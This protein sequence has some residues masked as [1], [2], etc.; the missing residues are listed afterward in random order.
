MQPTFV[1]GDRVL[2]KDDFDARY[3]GKT[4]VVED[5]ESKSPLSDLFTAPVSF[6]NTNL[7]DKVDP[8]KKD[9]RTCFVYNLEVAVFRNA[10]C[11]FC[12]FV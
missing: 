12:L 9:T 8:Q 5:R 10:R 3:I 4:G 6:F 11:T 2:V 1:S 7:E